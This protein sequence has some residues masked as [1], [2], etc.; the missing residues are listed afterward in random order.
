MMKR[1]DLDGDG[2]ISA[3]EWQGPKQRFTMIDAD[4]DGFITL[5]EFE[6]FQENHPAPGS[7]PG[8]ENMGKDQP[9]AAIPIRDTNRRAFFSGQTPKDQLNAA[10]MMESSLKPVYPTT[11]S[12]YKIDHIFGEQWKGPRDSLHSG[13]DIPAPFDEPIHAMADGVVVLKSDGMEGTRKFR[14]TQVVLQHSPADTGLPIWSY[15]L[16]S[17]FSKLPALEIGQRVRMGEYLGPNG[18]SGV[19]GQRRE[20]H[21]HLT[22]FVSDSPRFSIM[23]GVVVPDNG[24]FIDPVAL[25]RAR[26]PIDTAV[27]R[28]LPDDEKMVPITYKLQSGEVIPA[29][30]KIIWPFLCKP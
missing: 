9:P 28:Q 7:V 11:A 24:R 30:S 14:G 10:G 29:A 3:A 15:T 19:P 2:K 27:M 25:F 21:L 18:K 16:Y 6:T 22:V 5:V 23:N 12:C 8:T 13:A 1:F 26:L 20:P 4:G 17:H